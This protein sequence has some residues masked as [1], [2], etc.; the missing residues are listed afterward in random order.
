MERDCVSTFS[1]NS[2]LEVIHEEFEHSENI[3]KCGLDEICEVI[4]MVELCKKV[5][6]F[7]KFDV[8]YDNELYEICVAVENREM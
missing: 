7:E 5:E 4:D 2:G 8:N 3:D 6:D 1:A